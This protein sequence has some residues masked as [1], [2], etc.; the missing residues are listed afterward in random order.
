MI[1]SITVTNYL[2]DSLKLELARPEKSGFVVLGVSG[3]G[4]GKATIN[5]TEISTDDGA[6]FNSSR[7]PARNIVISLKYL[8]TESI[9]HTRHLSYKYFPIMKKLKLLI[10]TDTR[11]AEI[12]GYVE[13]N[14]PNIFSNFEGSNISI[15]CSNP[16]FKA[17]GEDSIVSTY[18]YGIEPSFEFPFS[19]E[20]LTEALLEFSIYR[21]NVENVVTYNGDFDIGM[22]MHIYSTGNAG[23]ITLTNTRTREQMTINADRIEALTGSGIIAGDEIVINTV[24]R[25][26]SVTLI[27]NGKSINILNALDRN[28]DWFTLTRGENLFAYT[29][30]SGSINLRFKIDYQVTY[31]GV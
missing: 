14:E 24:K 21:V 19:N 16:L 2:G 12:E 23:N 25:N 31:E 15:I 9:E 28:S 17:V 26:K 5:T 8:P 7:L 3:L 22:T 30:D 18:F 1:R 4:P 13:S 11:L 6:V 27:R 10:E 29:A 20:S